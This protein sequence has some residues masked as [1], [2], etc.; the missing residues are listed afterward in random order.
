MF[1][2]ITAKEDLSARPIKADDDRLLVAPL[3]TTTIALTS[4]D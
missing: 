3:S 2:T 1:S 4:E